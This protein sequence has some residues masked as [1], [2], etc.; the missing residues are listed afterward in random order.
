M[1]G[2]VASKPPVS[3]TM[4]RVT[5]F[6]D[7]SGDFNFSRHP[8]ASKYFMLTTVTLRDHE[9]CSGVL[10]RLRHDLAWEGAPGLLS[11]VS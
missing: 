6:A 9:A 10:S 5:V 11:C 2:R 3:E 1:T 7:E 8:K 4:G